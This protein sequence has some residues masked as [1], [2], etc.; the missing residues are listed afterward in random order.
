[1]D[2]PRRECNGFKLTLKSCYKIIKSTSSKS[3]IVQE[4]IC[5]DI[6]NQ[7]VLCLQVIY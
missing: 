6:F 1:M 4:N 2:L 3:D 7:Y 5:D